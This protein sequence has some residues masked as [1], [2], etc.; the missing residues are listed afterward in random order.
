VLDARLVTAGSRVVPAPDVAH[1]LFRIAQEALT[2][3]I[4]HAR[5]TSV[6]VG[7]VY[8]PT[9]VSLLVQDDGAGFDRTQVA[10]DGA[11][12]A[13]GLGGMAERAR[14]LGGTLE[15][16][17]TP[18]W[19][20]RI[21]AWIPS[22][23]DVPDDADLP[24]RLV[25]VLV[26][27]DHAVTR[28]GIVQVL[29]MSDPALQVVGE[30]ESGEQAVSAWRTLRPDV[31][32][33]DLQMLDGDGID[34]IA[35]IRA[36]DAS[37]SIV[38]VSAF[39]SDDLVAGAFRAGARGYLGKEASG[40]ELVRAVRAAS[41]GEMV[42]SGEA[43]ERLHAHLNGADGVRGLTERERQVLVLLERGSTDR[44]IAAALS[45]SVKTVEKHVGSILRKL[46]A[47]NRTQAVARARERLA[48]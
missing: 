26:V 43:V 35:R 46:G 42:V 45:I 47:H 9:G 38:A 5:A 28:A 44:E 10:E 7:L 24:G 36:E 32:L 30:A 29:L 17:S 13:L 31:V 6:R 4:R 12:H 41:R 16:D 3:A 40:L 37:A 15:L 23:S 2:N 21:R 48:G 14:L 1:T 39:A 11:V 34:A 18:G 19:G 25:R 8:S 22:A 33:M 20:T 27:D